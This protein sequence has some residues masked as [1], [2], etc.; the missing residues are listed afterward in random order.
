MADIIRIDMATLNV[1]KEPVP[2]ELEVLGGRYVTSKM[3]AKEVPATSNPLGPDNKLIFA[4]GLVAGTIAPSSGRIS[5]GTKSPLTGGI[6]EANAGTPVAQALGKLGVKALVFENW[7]ENK[8]DSLV[9]YIDK[10]EIKFSVMNEL[11][12]K[13][14]SD[15]VRILKEK[16]GDKVKVI[17]IGP[18]GELKLS[19]AGICFVDTDGMPVRYAAR[20]GVGAVMGS[21]GIKA[22][23]IN[24]EGLKFLGSKDEEG[25]KESIK[26]F[27]YGLSQDGTTKKGGAL[28][29]NGTPGVVPVMSEGFKGFPT[30]NFSLGKWR[31]DNDTCGQRQAEIVKERGRGTM[32]HAC[33]PGCVIRCSNIYPHS[34]GRLI[35]SVEY[36]SV[37]LLGSNLDI[38]NYDDIAD[39]ISIC[40]EVGVDTIDT[41]AAI[42]VLM[43]IGYLPFGDAKGAKQLIREIG[44]GTP[45]GRVVGSGA[46]IVGK[47]FGAYRVPTVKGQA[48]P[49]YDPRA[50]KGIGY[51]YA[52]SPMG[53]DHTAGY[54]IN[55]EVFAYNGQLD[56]FSYEGKAEY[57]R[58]EQLE[59]AFLDS[60]GY[61]LF[62][63]FGYIANPTAR[64]AMLRSLTAFTGI[65]L[66][67]ETYHEFA[68][69]IID[70][71]LDFNK[72]AGLTEIHDR[73]PEFFYK[74]TLPEVNQIFEATDE[75]IQKTWSK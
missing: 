7:P 56:P 67:A 32:G 11:K 41:G 43:D 31:A 65:E 54:T 33:N 12:M 3:I 21:K 66:K 13:Y 60:S 55:R 25:F 5:V 9:M 72:K 10:N 36:E 40:N 45:I 44:V 30:R 37:G 46:Q 58:E 15:T 47:V 2:K 27:I 52:T 39:L 23:V 68:R 61:C 74:E 71:E 70:V 24:D 57:S 69:E 42:G 6:K 64:D 4:P 1:Q 49:A 51:T 34:D 16:F 59:S 63:V 18:A 73:L 8:D 26:E 28:N 50:V 14:T 20:G 38:D 22:I 62:T 75:M 53:A 17:C 48:L 29:A 35:A 19:A